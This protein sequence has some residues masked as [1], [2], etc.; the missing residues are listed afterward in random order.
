M[1]WSELTA[2]PELHRIFT[3]HGLKYAMRRVLQPDPVIQISHEEE[4]SIPTINSI[5]EL[6]PDFVYVEFVPNTI[7]T[8]GDDGNQYD[9]DKERH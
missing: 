4:L 8:Y 1:G 9:F 6:F 5:I 3:E 2:A 7:F